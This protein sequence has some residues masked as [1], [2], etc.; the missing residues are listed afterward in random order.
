MT[1][2]YLSHAATKIC[3]EIV[4]NDAVTFDGEIQT[5]LSCTVKKLTEFRFHFNHRSISPIPGDFWVVTSHNMNPKELTQLF[6]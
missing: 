5:T 6:R 3:A 4:S 2:A 1:S